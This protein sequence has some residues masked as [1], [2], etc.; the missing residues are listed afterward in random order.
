VRQKVQKYL[1][2]LLIFFYQN[3][4][5]Q[6]VKLNIGKSSISL[7]EEFTITITFPKDL[8]K[9]YQSF[10]Y[11]AFPEFDTFLKSRTEYTEDKEAKVF[12][13]IQSYKPTKTGK[14]SLNPFKI[15]IGEKILS[16]PG[17]IV[18]VRNSTGK[19]KSK[20]P[21]KLEFKEEEQNIKFSVGCDE[22]EVYAGQGFLVT[23]SL[24]IGVNNKVKI[25]FKDLHQQA[26]DIA[27]M[28]T[29]SSCLM[30][31]YSKGLIHNPSFDSIKIGNQYFKILK[32][33]EAR[34]YPI[35]SED[36]TIPEI[37]FDLIKYK[38]AKAQ[39]V[40]WW[41]S[42]ELNLRSNKTLIKVKELPDHPLRDAVP[43]GTFRLKEAISSNKIQ[44]GQTLHYTAI[45]QGEGNLDMILS[46]LFKEGNAL[47]IF[48]P[49]VKQRI[50]KEKN[51]IGGK[52]FEYSIVPKEPGDYNLGNYYK[53]IYFDPH[54]KVY[55]TLISHTV[56]HI[57]GESL[58]NKEITS[59]Y[60]GSFYELAGK[61]S[62]RLRST[63]K[64][65]SIKFFANIIILFMLVSTAILVFKR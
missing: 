54:K 19:F 59:S 23:A 8:K 24:L 49:S 33:F 22:K 53:W 56:I 42:E 41:K 46:P 55:D 40:I 12:K 34:F 30:D 29:P 63:E 48:A 15:K 20:E 60:I 18:N 21:E 61:E 27:R 44:T 5:P 6:Q 31:E 11:S 17:T 35:T 2:I 25:H 52:V 26:I 36:I 9:E 50:V 4:F 39:N 7:Q 32:L 13:I 43:V 28:L 14:I 38:L 45:I 51:N 57:S 1:F 10:S 16:S 37:N 62:N 58:K 64:D 3:A 65:E 47:D